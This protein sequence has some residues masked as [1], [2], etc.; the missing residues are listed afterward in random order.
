V[1]SPHL[2][3]KVNHIIF[4]ISRIGF[5]ILKG[6]FSIRNLIVILV[7]YCDR[8]PRLGDILPIQVIEHLGKVINN[9]ASFFWKVLG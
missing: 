7:G 2:K 6:H 3:H 9:L 8:H 1:L 5:H 4:A